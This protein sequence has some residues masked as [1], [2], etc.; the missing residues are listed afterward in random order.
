MPSVALLHVKT[1]EGEVLLD[2]TPPAGN[3]W[4]G[5]EHAYLITSIFS[6]NE[7]RTPAFRTQ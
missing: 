7:A 4:S 6:D 5:P 1:A 2:Y 3:Q